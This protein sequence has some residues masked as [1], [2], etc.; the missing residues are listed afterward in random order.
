MVLII[1]VVY[2]LALNYGT[3]PPTTYR[4]YFSS[5]ALKRQRFEIFALDVGRKIELFFHNNQEATIT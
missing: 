4:S 5:I 3:I 1:N 2:Y